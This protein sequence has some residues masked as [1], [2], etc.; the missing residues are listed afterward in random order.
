M[1]NVNTKLA[2]SGKL[3][4]RG[5]GM[6]ARERGSGITP[7]RIVDLLRVECA[8]KSML[9]VSK[10]AGVGLAA[11]GRYLKGIGEPTTATLEKLSDYFKVSVPWL[12]GESERSLEEERWA[13]NWIRLSPEEQAG[14]I[15][16]AMADRGETDKDLI[17]ETRR[18][19]RRICAL[20]NKYGRIFGN[21]FLRIPPDDRQEVIEYLTILKDIT[22]AGDKAG[23]KIYIVGP[24]EK[25]E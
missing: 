20:S 22:R 1:E 23:H 25:S 11:I 12:R 13:Y 15:V 2:T 16:N 9:A 19:F 4:T 5:G 21:A 6:V 17:D 7:P 8:E 18:F 3:L 24:P 14:A 10:A